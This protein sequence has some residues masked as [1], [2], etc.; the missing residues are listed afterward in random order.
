[1]VGRMCGH[2]AM[3]GRS[4]ALRGSACDLRRFDAQRRGEEE[5]Q[6]SRAVLSAD[7]ISIRRC[8][9]GC[10]GRRESKWVSAVRQVSGPG[11]RPITPLCGAPGIGCSLA[12][13]SG[14]PGPHS[15]SPE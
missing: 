11:L 2:N 9:C 14:D 5:V 1:M 3:S 12:D 15:T 7:L 4:E 10:R 6:K 8:L 13:L